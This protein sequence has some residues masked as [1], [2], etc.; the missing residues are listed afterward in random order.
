VAVLNIMTPGYFSGGMGT[1]GTVAESD[2]A[3]SLALNMPD[4][5]GIGFS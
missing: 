1:A 5:C 4:C 2:S 3:K